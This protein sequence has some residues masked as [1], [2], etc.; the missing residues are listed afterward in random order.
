[1]VED[2]VKFGIAA[3]L[4]G[5]AATLAAT[6][7][8][9]RLRGQKSPTQQA[10]PVAPT[11]PTGVSEELVAVIGDVGGTNVRLTLRK[12][13]LRTRTSVEIKELTKISSQNCKGFAEALEQ[14]LEVSTRSFF[15]I[16]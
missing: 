12:L 13:N 6:A 11:A 15:A 8:F 7:L 5:A 10:A 3:G 14:F 2:K 4:A 9:K 1:M 16:I